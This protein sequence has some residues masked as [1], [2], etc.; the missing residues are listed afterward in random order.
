MNKEIIKTGLLN[1][2]IIPDILASSLLEEKS[3]KK[4][5]RVYDIYLKNKKMPSPSL[6]N[7]IFNFNLGEINEADTE[8]V[9]QLLCESN[10]VD[11]VCSLEE[12]LHSGEPVL[13]EDVH[14]LERRYIKDYGNKAENRFTVQSFEDL[15][16]LKKEMDA[17]EEE[18][19][20]TGFKSINDLTKG[21]NKELTG[22]WRPGS[23]YTIMGLS[24]Y[25]KSIF[26]SNFARDSWSLNNNVLYIST[27]MDHL[28]TYDRILK[29]FYRVE[30]FDDIVL[31][32]DRQ[33][34]SGRIEVVK[35]HPNDTTYLDIQ[36]I[37]DGL[38]WKPDVLY[39]DYADELKCHE[40]S[41]SEYEGQGIIYAGLKKLAEVNRL[42]VITATQTNRGAEDGENGGTKKWVGMGAIADSTKKIRLV[43]MLFSITQSVNEKKEH[44]LNLIILKN[45]FGQSNTRISF[46]IN[47]QTMR[48]EEIDQPI[49]K[50]KVPPPPKK[51][52][53]L[54]PAEKVMFGGGGDE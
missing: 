18:F 40:K 53:E 24:G 26:L 10:I 14:S 13:P 9:Y 52:I 25:G 35:V 31:L 49:N 22:G 36:N 17:K 46:S 34:P 42:P 7:G 30:N 37:I 3:A 38:N 41:N 43:D 5:K 27:E 45:R 1:P 47:Y 32:K 29:S 12:R 50:T 44:I 4:L 20:E 8:T 54:F 21:N 51:K 15:L 19:V 2:E 28:D 48:I 39:I 6:L 23:L 33:F 16:H 11:Y